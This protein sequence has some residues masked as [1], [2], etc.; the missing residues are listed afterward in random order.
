[1][2]GGALEGRLIL[3]TRPQREAG[4]L[5]ERLREE[6]AEPIEAP[7]IEILPPRDAGPVDRALRE[8]ARGEFEWVVFTS[9]RAVEAVV[10]RLVVLGLET[11][12][13]AKV[14][15][16]GEK[17]ADT[18]RDLDIQVD[19]VPK[20]Y[21]TETLAEAFPAGSG[22]VLLPRA[23]IAP[24]GLEEGLSARGWTPVRVDAYETRFPSELPPEALH[25][26]ENDRLDA[27]AFT[28]ASTVEGFARVAGAP[29]G[30][31]V[32]C[33]GPVTAEAA[34]RAGLEVDRVASPHT[35]EGLVHALRLAFEREK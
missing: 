18:L 10:A 8:V 21:T 25:A 33:I 29:S 3:V 2:A 34:R 20:V 1:M 31:K 22:R 15:A 17:T 28:S 23:D 14:A 16:V 35:V 9:P 32:I 13:P 19:L 6:G 26:I 30:A 11:A 12:I 5:A 7:T 4:S 27:I 24:D